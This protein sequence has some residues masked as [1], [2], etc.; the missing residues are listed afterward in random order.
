MLLHRVKLHDFIL[1]IIIKLFSHCKI[2]IHEMDEWIVL[3]EYISR[4]SWNL[5]HNRIS[6]YYNFLFIIWVSPKLPDSRTMIWVSLQRDLL[7]CADIDYSQW[8][9]HHSVVRC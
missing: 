3:R 9:M 7:S 6:N 4:V 8:W 2:L 1:N 5:G